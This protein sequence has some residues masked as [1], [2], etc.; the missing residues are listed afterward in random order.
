M[1]C[2]FEY[3]FETMLRQYG[4]SIDDKRQF[5]ALVKDV[6]PEEAK[7]VNLI[8]M[9]YN[10]GIA[11]DIQ[12][13][14]LLNNTFAFRYVKQLMDDYGISRVNADW[15]V[16]VWCTCYGN[17]VLGKACD[18]SLQK[19]GEGPAIKDDST[20]TA[21]KAYGELFVYE[22]SSKGTGL[23]VTG[24]HGDKNQTII[25]QNKSGNEPVVE[26]AGNSFVR[27]SIEE[28]ILTEGI[29]YIGL[30]A[31]SDCEKLHQVVL[32][33]SIEE[34]E[35]SAFENCGSLKSVSLPISLKMIGDAA[36][37]GTG[38]RTLDIPKSVFWIG[39]ELLANCKSLEHIRIM[40]NIGR[41]PDKMFEGCESLSKVGLHEKLTVIGERAFFG[42]SALDFIV[43]PD[44]VQEI[45]A[46]AFAGTDDMFIVQCSFGSYAEHYCRKNKIK[47]Q[48]V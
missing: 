13:S 4:N 35:N 27:S 47:Y 46:D 24:F 31:F 42:C 23:A 12:K 36:F 5:T 10:M 48:L 9:A 21:G 32:P 8:L 43:I 34:I 37:K 45:G 30:N 38:L 2:I 19:Q 26:I 44:S 40:E 15:I 14:S 33:I 18:I 20:S 16:S 22:K 7:S 11:Q 17:K 3:D 6:F 28:A 29:K 39:D 25:F 1:I 41:I